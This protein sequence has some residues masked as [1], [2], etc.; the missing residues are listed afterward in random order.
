MSPVNDHDPVGWTEHDQAE[1]ETRWYEAQ[2][3][4]A[5]WFTEWLNTEPIG[6]G[7]PG[8]SWAGLIGT[9]MVAAALAVIIFMVLSL[10]GAEPVAGCDPAV[11]PA[12]TASRHRDR[13]QRDRA[14]SHPDRLGAHRPARPPFVGAP[15][16]GDWHSDRDYPAEHQNGGR[17]RP[18]RDNLDPPG[19][20]P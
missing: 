17:R 10:R 2:D 18:L 9:C 3:P 11:R 15:G 19:R 14:D 12:S 4:A 5:E 7:R 6:D 20:R 8:I 16:R 1:L 13:D